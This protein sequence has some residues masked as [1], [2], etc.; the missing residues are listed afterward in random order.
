MPILIK[1]TMERIMAE[2]SGTSSQ[3]RESYS[4]TYFTLNAASNVFARCG[5]IPGRTYINFKL[6]YNSFWP[7]GAG[8][9][10]GFHDTPYF[11][12]SV[13][14]ISTRGWQIMPTTLLV[15]PPGIS[16]IPTALSFPWPHNISVDVGLS[17]YCLHF[18]NTELAQSPTYSLIYAMIIFFLSFLYDHLELIWV[19][20]LR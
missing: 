5:K 15:T 9:A 19:L 11:V 14:P 17:F 10:W 2:R 6:L 20:K 13:N 4:N 3:K 7:V 1:Q 12:R 8:G 16:D 18:A